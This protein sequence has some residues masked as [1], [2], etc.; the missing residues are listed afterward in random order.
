M[1]TDLIPGC[2]HQKKY[3][4]RKKYPNWAKTDAGARNNFLA[5]K[6][7]A[8]QLPK[9]DARCDGGRVFFV[10]GLN[11]EGF[12]KMIRLVDIKNAVKPETVFPERDRTDPIT[13]PVKFRER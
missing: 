6:M 3:S 1:V 13:K 9:K 11:T 8:P 4:W 2:Y 7:F 5:L 10:S 12:L